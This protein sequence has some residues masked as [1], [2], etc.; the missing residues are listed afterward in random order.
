MVGDRWAGLDTAKHYL[1]SKSSR[2][3]ALRSGRKLRKVI[4]KRNGLS[5]SLS[6][7]FF[8]IFVSSD[9]CAC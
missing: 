4:L 6:F 5:L 7:L 8:L 1:C 2:E 9:V 3:S